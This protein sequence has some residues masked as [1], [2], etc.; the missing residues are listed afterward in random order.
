MCISND[1]RHYSGNILKKREDIN[2]DKIVQDIEMAVANANLK[3]IFIEKT[4]SYTNEGAFCIRFK[5]SDTLENMK[6]RQKRIVLDIFNKLEVEEEE[7]DWIIK[8]GK[9]TY[10]VTIEEIDG[11]E[12]LVLDFLYEYLKLNPEDIFW[13]QYEWYYN[14]ETIKEIKEKEFDPRWCYKKPKT[15]KKYHMPIHLRGSS[16]KKMICRTCGKVEM[17][18]VEKI[19]GKKYYGYYC[20]NCKKWSMKFPAPLFLELIFYDSRIYKIKLAGGENRYQIEKIAEIAEISIEEA[21]RYLP[22]GEEIV[23]AE[24]SAENIWDM[25]A[26]LLKNDL[27]FEIEPEFPFWLEGELTEEEKKEINKKIHNQLE[28]K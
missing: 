23:I 1:F 5:I 6:K 8:D 21:R 25:A 18:K 3:I 22:I 20:T 16:T 15:K 24:D 17:G 4:Y 27:Y 12:K 28:Q 7:F 10:V 13:N 11:R 19:E 14:Y 26:Y 2:I 9:L